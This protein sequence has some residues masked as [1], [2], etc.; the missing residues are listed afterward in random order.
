M[1]SNEAKADT[2]REVK[3]LAG[4]PAADVERLASLAAERAVAPGTLIAREGHKDHEWILV[5]SGHA[6]VTH[7]GAEVGIVGPGLVVGDLAASGG[8][9]CGVTLTAITFMH[10]LVLSSEPDPAGLRD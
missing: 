5:V 8:L 1:M 3:C 10:L 7:D 6:A 2:L 9:A 4:L